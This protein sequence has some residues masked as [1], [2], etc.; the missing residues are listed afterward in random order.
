M[1]RL[2]SAIATLFLISAC[3]NSPE[4]ETGEIRT[5]SLIRQAINEPKNPRFSVDVKKIIT[6]RKIDAAKIPVL[7]VELESGQNGTLTPYPG[8]GI[9]QTWLGAD[10]ATITFEQGVLKASRGMGDDVMGGNSS[11]PPWHK[12]E[13]SADYFRFLSYLDGNNKVYTVEFKCKIQISK[14]IQ[15]LEI[16]NVYFKTVLFQE[17]CSSKNNEIKNLYYIDESWIVR[18]SIQFHGKTLGYITTER[19][20]R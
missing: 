13:G 17:T 18:K 11:K 9:G 5:L 8:R 2:L 20:E 4:L 7:F 3:S 6:R 14:D 15:Y 19:L 16:L 10:G 12:I 1:I